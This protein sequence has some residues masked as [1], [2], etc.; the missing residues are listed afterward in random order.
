MSKGDQRDDWGTVVEEVDAKALL[1]KHA[2]PSWRRRFCDVVDLTDL[3]SDCIIPDS[4]SAPES[5]V[6]AIVL[7]DAGR[8]LK[9]KLIRQEEVPA[10]EAHLM[11]A[12]T[13][14]HDRL[15][16][17]IGKTDP[18][19]VAAAISD[20]ITDGKIRFPFLFANHLYDF[21]ADRYEDEKD[22][23]TNEETIELLDAIPRGVFQYG[24]FVVG[25]SG[26][27]VG[28]H[29]RTLRSMSR[30]PAFHCD[31]P[32]CRELHS[33]VLST[34]HSASINSERGKLERILRAVKSKPADWS[35]LASEIDKTAESYFGNSWTAPM[36]TL[37]GDCLGDQE[38]AVLR[39]HL[40]KEV[41]LPQ[42]T[43]REAFLEDLL[44]HF[45]D[46]SLSRAIDFLVRREKLTVPSGEV[47]RPVSTA[48][49]RSGAF[50]LQPQ[51]GVNGVRFV[52]GDPGLPI[53]RER[54]LFRRIYLAAGESERL[55]LDWQLREIDGVSLEVRLD[56]YL[57]TKPPT[58]ALTRLVLSGRAS[59]I[60]ASELVGA[61]EFDDDSDQQII[62][63]L[64][65]KLGFD[66]R[67]PE[68][69]H[70]AYW[71]QH[72][73]V[74][75]AVQSWLGTGAD[76]A[77][78]FK[79]KAAE[80]F[81]ALEGVLEDSLAFA[82]W[83][84]LSDHVTSSRPFTYTP[85]LDRP[86]GLELLDRYTRSEGALDPGERIRFNGKLT[87]HPLIRGFAV[88]GKVLALLRD[89]REDFARPDS[90]IP[91]YARVTALQRFPFKSTL[92]YLDISEHSQQRVM[93]A[94]EHVTA[95]L[96]DHEVGRIRNDHVH[97]RRT[98]PE[99][100]EMAETLEAVAQAVRSI[101]NLGL[102]LNVFAPAEQVTDRWGRRTVRFI[103]PRSLEHA[104]NRPSSLQWA[105]LPSLRRNQFLVRVAAFDDANEVLRFEHG[106]VSDFSAMWTDYPKPRRSVSRLAEPSSSSA[107]AT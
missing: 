46:V 79:G 64:L 88:L 15:F 25:P 106:H 69:L 18:E 66:D 51:L 24:R 85:D 73:R 58:E 38:L 6:S 10:R 72:E 30:V 98:S 16:V 45:N 67:D 28:N 59:A 70:A 54:D 105:G 42:L 75:A 56:E 12:L 68:D 96:Q 8:E 4:Y 47:R 102:G 35:G 92:P 20:Q 34:G 11:C 91:E 48:H 43:S 60:A 90:E 101:E 3:L 19:E 94:L 78:D 103:G 33:V 23:L 62:S 27:R 53:L 89:R 52:S 5:F 17:D 82:S 104:I 95:T 76:D 22:R 7:S 40:D 83:V 14:G 2:D 81:S 50:K 84:F 1:A 55:E 80:Y 61:G 97:F 44:V 26:V 29:R 86:I 13:L 36:V 39:D 74:A 65:W 9:S 31:D 100:A 71:R 87:M 37:I 41:P 107:Q 63:R 32:V 93:A 49:L 77:A 21:F 57:R 99:I